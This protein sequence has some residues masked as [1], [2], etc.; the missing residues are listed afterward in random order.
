M[1][2][3]EY[4]RTSSVKAALDVL[5]KNPGASFIAG[6]TNLVD[7]MKKGVATPQRLVDINNLPLKQI[8]ID[9]K[10]LTIG[11]LALNSDVAENEKV[12]KNYPLLVQAINAGA[13]AQLRN[14]ATIGGNIMQRTRCTYFYDTTLPCNKRKPG[15]GCGALKG[16]NRMHAIFGAS[17]KCIAVQPSDMSVALAALDATVM[18][19]SSKGE[20]KIPF[21]DFHRLPGDIP[22]KD[23]NLQPGELITA[24]HVPVNSFNKN[25]YLKIRDRASY[26]FALVSVAVALKVNG[27]II[28]SARLAMGGVAHKPW[29]LKQAE[30][31][32]TGSA[33]HDL[34]F[35]KLTDNI[36]QDAK[37]YEH[38]A[39]KIKLGKAAIAEAINKALQ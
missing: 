5:A 24:I 11:A 33:I 7:L 35:A 38:N 8:S 34:S 19:S 1:I 14:M 36:M 17:D 15:S 30:E 39:F 37:T 28:Q 4:S 13:S 27:N 18:V 22:E 6:G 10:G 9:A 3:F 12:K 29:R 23:N 26:A 32:L 16:Y 2:N 31:M 20:R 25:H 21:T